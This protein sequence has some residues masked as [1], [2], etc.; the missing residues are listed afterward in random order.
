MINT[1]C[2][3]K[4]MY[5]STPYILSISYTS[6]KRSIA[7]RDLGLLAYSRALSRISYE[8]NRPLTFNNALL[9]SSEMLFS[10]SNSLAA[11]SLRFD[12]NNPMIG[13][14]NTA[15]D[16]KY[17][18]DLFQK[19]NKGDI[20]LEDFITE[21]NSWVKPYNGMPARIIQD[22]NGKPIIGIPHPFVY[23]KHQGGKLNYLNYI[24]S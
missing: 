4:E 11:K 14:N 22:I 2:K 15:V 7:L 18:Y 3:S 8:P 21:F 5:F 19:A 9:S 24:N 6:F 17:I 16:N 23:K 13:W 10:V 12:I 20:P 1:L